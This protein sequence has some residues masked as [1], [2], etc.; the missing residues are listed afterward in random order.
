MPV[1]P[2]I[3]GFDTG[4]YTRAVA[5]KV[6]TEN[7]SKVLYPNDNAPQGRELRLKQQYFFVACSLH[8]I[9]RRFHIRNHNWDDFPEKVVI[10]LNDTHPV[11]AIPEL[12]RILMD[13]NDLGWDQAWD[14]TRRT[15]A[16]TCHN[17]LPEALENGRWI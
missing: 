10:Q 6:S 8:D 9:I 1:T 12:M 13:V 16:Y 3:S 5:E 2:L 4:D 14:I 17:L 7:I 11:I 15:F